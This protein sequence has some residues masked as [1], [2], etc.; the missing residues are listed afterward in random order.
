MD[1]ITCDSCKTTKPRALFKRYASLAQTRAWVK[2]P[3]A[4][5]RIVYYGAECNA[6]HSRGK[7]SISQITPEELR[8]RLIK[9]GKGDEYI[10]LA[11][12]ERKARGRKRATAAGLKG[13]KVREAPMFA[14]VLDTL[15]LFVEKVTQRR[16]YIRKAK[17]DPAAT[18]FLNGVLAQSKIA[19]DR[20]REK[21]RLIKHAPS[22]WQELLTDNEKDSL[23]LLFRPMS[24]ELKDRLMWVLEELNPPKPQPKP[25]QQLMQSAAK[26]NEPVQTQPTTEPSTDSDWFDLIK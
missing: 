21:K 17:T 18:Q 3:N 22:C 1:T 12:A 25:V 13:I 20:L 23:R 8:K 24:G 9:E 15:N 14:E 5:R 16:A 2:N 10:R 7:R 11:V 26:P 4:Q 19:R 6:C